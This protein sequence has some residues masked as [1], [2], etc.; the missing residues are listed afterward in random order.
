MTRLR[1]NKMV[2]LENLYTSDMD[3]I[4]KHLNGEQVSKEELESIRLRLE[5]D[6]YKIKKGFFKQ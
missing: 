1:N 6:L 3:K 5:S 4:L 2:T